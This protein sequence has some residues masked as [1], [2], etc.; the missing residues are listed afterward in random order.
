[1]FAVTDDG[2]IAGLDPDGFA[3][4]DKCRL[5]FKNLFNQHLGPEFSKY[6]HF[7]IFDLE[8]KQVVAIECERAGDPAFLTHRQGE[9]F[10]IRSG[11]SNME[12]TISQAISYLRRR[13]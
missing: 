6:V 12:L 3:N 7:E 2:V 4:D 13:F 5:H 9:S 8:H 10:Y 1:M 11:P